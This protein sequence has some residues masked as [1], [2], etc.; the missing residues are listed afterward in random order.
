MKKVKMNNTDIWV[1]EI[2]YGTAS[3][4]LGGNIEEEYAMLDAF[5][6]AGGNFIDTARVY[7]DWVPGE[8]GRSE[9][10]LGE[11]LKAR[12][13]PNEIVIAT[14]GGHPEFGEMHKSRLTSEDVEHDIKLSLKG[15][16]VERID[17]Y[18]LHRDDRSLPVE[19]IIDYLEHFRARG[20]IRYY[21][22]SYRMPAFS[23]REP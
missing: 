14:K 2:S 4:G 15:L 7:S 21:A 13:H 8:R 16:G 6:D 1:S 20:Y 3:L 5:I 17:L 10:V 23:Y 22:C 18:Y 9:R 12:R 19:Y 11:W